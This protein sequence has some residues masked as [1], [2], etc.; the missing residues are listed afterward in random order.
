MLEA[1]RHHIERSAPGWSSDCTAEM[2]AEDDK[3]RE[4]LERAEE[5]AAEALA[6]V[7][8]LERMIEQMVRR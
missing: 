1:M 5:K 4:R 8:R 6:K 7:V 3:L 2:Q